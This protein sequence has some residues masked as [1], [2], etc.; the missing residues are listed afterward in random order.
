MRR[1]LSRPSVF[2]GAV[3]AAAGLPRLLYLGT[4]SPA[5]DPEHYLW[6]LADS[7]LRHGTIGFDGIPSADN[8]P[9]YPLF[10]SCARWLSGDNP[11]AVLLLQALLDSLGAVFLYLLARALTGRTRVALLSA[12][13]YAVYPLL[14][15]HSTNVGEFSLLSVLLIVFAYTMATATSLTRTSLAGM[16]LGLAILMRAM[17]LPILLCTVAVLL[18]QRRRQA[19]LVLA[20]T[21]VLVISPWVLRNHALNRAI[22]PT[23]S[24]LLLFVMNSPYAATMLPDHNLDLLKEYAGYV[25]LRDRPDLVIDH[26][27]RELDRF[28]T[29][30]AI[31]DM[32]ARPWQT[33]QLKMRNVAYH[34]WP[35]L[36]PSRQTIPDTRLRLGRNGEV[37]VENAPPQPL[38]EQVVYTASYVPVALAALVGVWLRRSDLRRDAV[39]WCIVVTFVATYAIYAPATRYRV[40]MEFVLL[41]YAA[42]AIDVCVAACRRSARTSGVPV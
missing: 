16:W 37:R 10:L 1:W 36:I 19:A 2:Y 40:S 21:T 42:L 4:L 26:D 12:L 7:V 20:V 35:T 9:L 18:T 38:L 25:L 27:E 17:I 6:N 32:M 5:V 22:W 13:L 39:L 15:R 11:T 8:E 29:R 31:E 28:F 30:M 3:F 14:I 33:L 24:G 23:R 41:Y 34:F